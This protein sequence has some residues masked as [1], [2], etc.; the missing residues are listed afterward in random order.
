MSARK[1]NKK[2][3][4]NNSDIIPFNKIE[5]N[6]ALNQLIYYAYDDDFA[7]MINEL[8]MPK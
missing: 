3:T 4:S 6:V 1:I 7:L 2:D 5:D 8:S